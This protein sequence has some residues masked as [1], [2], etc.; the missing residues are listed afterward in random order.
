MLINFAVYK[1]EIKSDFM[2]VCV[3]CGEEFEDMQSSVSYF[4]CENCLI[5]IEE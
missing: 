4:I 5:E 3:E 1:Y 2:I